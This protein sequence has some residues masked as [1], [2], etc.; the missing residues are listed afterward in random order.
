MGILLPVGKM[1][2]GV[3]SSLTNIRNSLQYPRL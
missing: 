2:Y 1:L 3:C